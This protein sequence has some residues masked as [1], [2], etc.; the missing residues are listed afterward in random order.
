MILTAVVAPLIAFGLTRRTAPT[1]RRT[2]PVLAAVAFAMSLW[3]WHSPAPYLSTF[4]SDAVYWLMHVTTFGA[5]LWLW[6]AIFSAWSERLGT[7]AA[8][9][10]LTILQMGL[11]GAVIT[12][13]SKPLY[14]PHVYTALAWGLSALADQ[15]LGGVIMWVP[16]GLI[17]AATLAAGF[18]SALNR[19]EAR[20]FSRSAA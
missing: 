17:L 8:A 6:L 11:L 15:Q 12:F 4:T 14:A 13:A 9:I 2:G 3:V 18:S 5:A 1:L 7:A 19:S 20:A 16:A 10:M